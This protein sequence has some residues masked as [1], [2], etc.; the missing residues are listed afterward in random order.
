MKKIGIITYH[1][2]YNYG[3]MLQAFALQRYLEDN[4][5]DAEIINYTI[6]DNKEKKSDI[7]LSRLKRIF[8]PIK[9][10]TMIFK[11]KNPTIIQS[12]KERFDDFYSKY[13]KLGNKE[14]STEKELKENLPNYDIYM[15]G[16]DQMWNP[17]IK[18]RSS[19]FYLSFVPNDK[20][21]VSYAPSIGG[22]IISDTYQKEMKQYL[23]KFKYLSCRDKIGSEILSKLLN[24]Q[25][26]TVVDPTL[27]LSKNEW[28]KI[29]KPKENIEEKYI[30][31]YFLGN[32]KENIKWA[33]DFGKKLGVKV[34]F[35]YSLAND[36]LEGLDYLFDVGPQEFLWLIKNAQYV[37]TDSFHGTIFSIN[38]NKQFFSFTKRKDGEGSDNNRIYQVLEEFN[39]KDR[40]IKNTYDSNITENDIDYDKVDKI[41]E[42]KISDSK[43][44]LEQIIR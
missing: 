8:N 7:L 9:R 14:Y 24:R 32:K 27:L 28:S 10:K 11:L 25:V 35:I 41:L 37:C 13:I 19:A 36:I 33:I 23:E 17:Y 12:H 20:M 44:Y 21:K 39:I 3:S 6:K 16:S 31:C 26:E 30:V 43:K 22:K 40:L 38:F 2:F 4:G 42:E 1:K 15:V 34:Y 18:I 29:A 5:S